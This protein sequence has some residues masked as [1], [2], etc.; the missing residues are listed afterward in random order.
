MHAKEKDSQLFWEVYELSHSHRAPILFI[1][2]LMC[3]CTYLVPK[4]M[5]FAHL[6]WNEDVINL[7]YKWL[8]EP[9]QYLNG[10]VQ[11]SLVQTVNSNQSLKC[12]KMAKIRFELQL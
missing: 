6:V 8:G 9:I 1:L 12:A 4:T 2:Q 5:N 10:L 3:S 11:P 7:N